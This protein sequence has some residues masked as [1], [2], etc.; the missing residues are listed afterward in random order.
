SA[1][2]TCTFPDGPSSHSVRG[3]IFDKDN[4]YT[5]YTTTVTVN[6]VAP[7]ATLANGGSVNEHSAGSVSFSNQHDV[8]P[9]D[10]A[11]GFMYSYDFDNDGTF[12]IAGSSSPSATVPASYLDDGPGSRTVHGRILDKDG[13]YTDYTTIITINNVAPTATFNAPASVA[14]GSSIGLSLT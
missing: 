9:T 2:T 5:D 8:S 14:E 1:S 3:R 7:T 12:E 13:G 6:N 10:Q 11:A 4:G